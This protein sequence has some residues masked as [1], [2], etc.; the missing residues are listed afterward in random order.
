MGYRSDVGALF[1]T[2]DESK[3]GVIKMWLRENLPFKD[4]EWSPDAFYEEED[5]F[6]FFVED[7][8]WYDTYPEIE[9]F[10]EVSEKFVELFCDIDDAY[11]AYEF[12]RIGEEDEDI[13]KKSAGDHDYRISMSKAIHFD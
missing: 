7:V 11:G 13:E 12:I 3:V 5:G 1:Y 6:R 4:W 10:N 8:K 2:Q 9:R